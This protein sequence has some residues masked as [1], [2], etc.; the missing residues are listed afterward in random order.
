MKRI[1]FTESTGN[2]FLDIGFSPEQAENLR[3]RSELM[4]Q[5]CKQIKR[6]KLTQTKAARIFGVSQPRISDLIRGRIDL[7]S[8]DSLIDMLHRAGA[9]VDIQVR[10]A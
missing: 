7:F 5:I 8:V 4:N 1:K 10:A 2:V 9:K 3:L 6:R